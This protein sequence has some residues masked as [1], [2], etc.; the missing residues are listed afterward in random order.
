MASSSATARENRQTHK[1]P[2]TDSRPCRSRCEK[3]C[4]PTLRQTRMRSRMA[5]AASLMTGLDNKGQPREALPRDPDHVPFDEAARKVRRTKIILRC[6]PAAA[7][8]KAVRRPKI[9]L[10]MSRA[11]PKASRAA[12]W[13]QY[14]SAKTVEDWL[15]NLY[16]RPSRSS[17][18]GSAAADTE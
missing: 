10:H 15:S 16:H 6:R 1:M 11:E 5:G 3:A 13:S 18:G 14:S 4:R 2:P 17:G 8:E 12:T 9:I 7:P